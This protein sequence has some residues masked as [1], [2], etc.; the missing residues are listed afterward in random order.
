MTVT[1]KV[2]KFK[3]GAKTGVAVI[4]G[5]K[6]C[7]DAAGTHHW[8]VEAYSV[9][10]SITLRDKLTL[11]RRL[12]LVALTSGS[13]SPSIGCYYSA[14]AGANES[15]VCWMTSG[16]STANFATADA[17]IGTDESYVVEIE[18]AIAI[19]LGKGSDGGTAIPIGAFN[20]TVH[21]GRVFSA[22]NRSDVRPE[23][24]ILA[25]VFGVRLVTTGSETTRYLGAAITSG[26][27]GTR[28]SFIL[29]P[30][31]TWSRVSGGTNVSTL[32]ARAS[33]V[34][35]TTNILADV[36]DGPSIERLVPVP[37]M[38]AIST[39]A[40]GHF[41]YTRYIRARRYAIGAVG[42]GGI[43]IANGDV[44]ASAAP[45]PTVIGW[46]HNATAGFGADAGNEAINLLHI[47]CPPGQEVIVDP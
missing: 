13:P 29:L 21:A 10:A 26:S 40:N 44:F 11:Q 24:G 1:P 5:I 8:E 38:G 23:E 39:T 14:A 22:H 20:Y 35:G 27:H 42:P 41:A 43:T 33:S 47:W 32:G 12:R 28:Q 37:V 46:R 3:P 36:G 30:D 34:S 4:D 19:C 9:G 2:Y 31:N 7:M 18:D 17:G 25:G 16:L 45:P 6:R 15:P